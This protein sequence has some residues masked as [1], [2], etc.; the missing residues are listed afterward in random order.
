MEVEIINKELRLH[1]YGFAGFVSD[2]DYVSTIFKLT[3][4]MWQVVKAES[5]KNFGKNIWVYEYDEKVFAGVE[6]QEIPK[7]ESGLELKTIK[8]NNYGYYKHIG[9]Y[10]E[11]KEAGEKMKSALKNKGYTV[12]FP[13]IEIYGHWTA[14][15]TKLETELFMNL[16]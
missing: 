7:Q 9:A 1:L 5:L 2:K 16:I 10:T 11:L 6:L 12:T 13:Y 14:D 4:K 3:D 15:E 8:L